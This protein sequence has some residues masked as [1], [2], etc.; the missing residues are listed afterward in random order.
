M[1]NQA[2]VDPA[3]FG[4]YLLH[5]IEEVQLPPP[6]SWAP[7]TGG[8]AL[9]AGLL[10]LLLGYLAYKGLRHWW[11]NRYR[12][13]AL[14]QLK[15]CRRHTESP[16]ALARQIPLLLKATALQAFP[17]AQVASLSG[18]RWLEFLDAQYPGPPFCGDLGRLML[19]LDYAPPS[20]QTIDAQQ[21]RQLS[22]MARHWI[23]T[24]QRPPGGPHHHD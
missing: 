7:Q 1:D 12:R 15:Q 8:W 24:H 4:N 21:A 18:E 5:G 10:V 19:T 3:T 20:H 17:R 14:H 16:R 6:V 13:Q 2:P 22:E 11:C 23:R 9:L